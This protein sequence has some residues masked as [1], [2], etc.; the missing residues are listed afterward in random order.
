MAMVSPTPA[1]KT[2]CSFPS[3]ATRRCVAAVPSR[4]ESAAEE[5]RRSVVAMTPFLPPVT[6]RLGASGEMSRAK[7][8]PWGRVGVRNEG[9]PV[10]FIRAAPALVPR[11]HREGEV[12]GAGTEV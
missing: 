4:N 7:V 5:V 11:R 10:S 8:G 6:T 1:T 12:E 3:G 2:L 9:A